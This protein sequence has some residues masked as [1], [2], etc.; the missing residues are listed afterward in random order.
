MIPE[1]KGWVPT[2]MFGGRKT[3]LTL[4]SSISGRQGVLSRR[5]RG[6]PILNL[7]FSVEFLKIF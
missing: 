3:S 7:H 2:V 4:E 1:S 5:I 6:F